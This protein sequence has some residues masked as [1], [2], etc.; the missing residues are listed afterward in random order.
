MTL[1]RISIIQNDEMPKAIW[2]IK[3]YGVR[4]W[5]G[6]MAGSCE[7]G[8]ETSGSIKHGEFLD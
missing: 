4:V 5:N 7:H 8:N 1:P 6:P 3:K 2:F